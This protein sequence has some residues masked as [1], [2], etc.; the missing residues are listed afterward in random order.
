M[1]RKLCS[2]KEALKMG[3]PTIVTH[4]MQ[5]DINMPIEIQKELALKELILSTVMLC[6]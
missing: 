3:I 2:S 5:R 6:G 4:P 1:A